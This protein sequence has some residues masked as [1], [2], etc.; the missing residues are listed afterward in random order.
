VGECDAK[1]F[2]IRSKKYK[3]TR[4][5]VSCLKISRIV[6]HTHTHTH[7]HTQQISGTLNE[8]YV[9]IHDHAFISK[10]RSIL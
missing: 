6:S 4:K 8:R 2:K 1:L 9:R 7:T 10:L 3:K 5:K